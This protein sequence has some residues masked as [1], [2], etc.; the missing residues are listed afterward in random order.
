[1][2][3]SGLHSWAAEANTFDARTLAAKFANQ[4][5]A[6]QVATGFADGEEDFHT[7]G[8]WVLGFGFRASGYLRPT[9]AAEIVARL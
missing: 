8:C 2:A 3:T 9:F 7:E 1:L 5:C 6:V 4:V